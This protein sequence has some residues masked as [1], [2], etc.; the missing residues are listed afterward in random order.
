M[1][2]DRNSEKKSRYAGES[3]TL[4]FVDLLS[5]LLAFFVLVFS[6]STVKSAGWDS[7]INSM[8]DQFGQKKIDVKD[9]PK[10]D[11]NT[12]LTD[13]A[14]NILYLATLLKNDFGSDPLF[15]GGDI[16]VVDKKVILSF[17]IENI[18]EPESHSLSGPGLKKILPLGIKLAQFP[19]NVIVNVYSP[20]SV[21]VYPPYRNNRERALALARTVAAGLTNRGYNRPIAVT[22]STDDDQSTGERIEIQILDTATPKG[23]YD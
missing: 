18:F 11:K 6:M 21:S 19:N 17:P 16:S 12:S 8:A 15:T 14:L 4:T 23:F 2:H 22:G 1:M 9:I 5:L 13:D 20:R 3:W 10:S 7:L